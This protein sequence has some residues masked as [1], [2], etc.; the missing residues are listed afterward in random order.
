M[1]GQKS[2]HTARSRRSINS[3]NNDRD[4][5]LMQ[6]FPRPTPTHRTLSNIPPFHFLPHLPFFS[7]SSNP[8]HSYI[9][10]HLVQEKPNVDGRRLRKNYGYTLY[11]DQ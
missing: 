1:A 3:G 10:I 11:F 4:F 7:L 2:H 8:I 9:A 5:E 6:T